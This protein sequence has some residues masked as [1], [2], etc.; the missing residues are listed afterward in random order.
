MKPVSLFPDWLSNLTLQQQAVLMAAVRGQDGDRK[1]T[2]FKVIVSALRA[3]IM[4]AAHTGDMIEPGQHVASFMTL[5]LFTDP[6]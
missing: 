4:K 1:H 3:S 2:G 6:S 5:K